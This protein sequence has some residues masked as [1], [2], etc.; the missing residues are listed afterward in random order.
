MKIVTGY[1]YMNTKATYTESI[2]KFRI[3]NKLVCILNIKRRY[4][5]INH[6]LQDKLNRTRIISPN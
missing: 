4:Y 2:F 6:L 1:I 3:W 5:L